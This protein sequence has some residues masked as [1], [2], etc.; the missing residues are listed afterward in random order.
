MEFAHEK[1]EKLDWTKP[2]NLYFTKISKISGLLAPEWYDPSF[3]VSSLFKNIPKT[4]DQ[5]LKQIQVDAMCNGKV[6]SST[7]A[8][9][10][11]TGYLIDFHDIDPNNTTWDAS[12]QERA[13]KLWK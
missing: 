10:I 9:A 1:K 2:S 7:P 11:K 5:S 13:K 4:Y 8:S 6:S 3:T 12:V